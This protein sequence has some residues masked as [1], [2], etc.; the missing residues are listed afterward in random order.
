MRVIVFSL[1]IIVVG[2]SLSTTNMIVYAQAGIVQ[3][4]GFD[5]NFCK[6]GEMLNLGINWLFGFMAVL[7]VV[8][9]AIAGFRLV[10]SGGNTAERDWAKARIGYVVIG[11]LIMLSSWLIVDTILRGLTGSEKG[12]QVWGSFDIDNCGGQVR[13]EVDADNSRDTSVEEAF[14]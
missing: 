14:F 11:F 6:F 9:L 7:A 3:C 10:T 8:V 2:L 1:K 4:T 5:C 13:A 12:M